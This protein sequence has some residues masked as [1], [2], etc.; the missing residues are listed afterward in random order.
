MTTDLDIRAFR[1]ELDDARALLRNLL[2]AQEE[3]RPAM[4]GTADLAA[5]WPGWAPDRIRQELFLRV[6]Y[7]AGPGQRIAVHRSLVAEIDRQLAA[8][9]AALLGPAHGLHHPSERGAA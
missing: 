3:S 9:A 2:Q 8:E 5:H 6:R 1:R 4:L 7:R